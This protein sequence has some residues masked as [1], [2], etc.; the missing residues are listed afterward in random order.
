M[1]EFPSRSEEALRKALPF[2]AEE[3]SQWQEVALK[4]HKESCRITEEASREWDTS[5]ESKEV[6]AIRAAL[7]DDP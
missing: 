1:V 6:K 4:R 7:A 5:P 2:T 3:V